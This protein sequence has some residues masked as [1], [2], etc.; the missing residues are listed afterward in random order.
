MTIAI[1]TFL[2]GLGH[3]FLFRYVVPWVMSGRTCS[4]FTVWSMLKHRL[5]PGPLPAAKRHHNDF[6]K[7]K[8]PGP[9]LNFDSALHDELILVIF[10]H[11]TWMDLCAIQSTNHLWSRLASDNHVRLLIIYTY[12]SLITSFVIAMEDNVCQRVRTPEATR[13]TRLPNETWG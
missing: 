13:F 10:S 2:Y 3:L 7:T 8:N 1:Q 4:S 11:L 12:F 5:S 9:L 6:N